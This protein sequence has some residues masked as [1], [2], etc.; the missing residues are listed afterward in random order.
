MSEDVFYRFCMCM[1]ICIYVIETVFIN[2]IESVLVST[3][4]QR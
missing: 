1:C 4:L 3:V 2:V